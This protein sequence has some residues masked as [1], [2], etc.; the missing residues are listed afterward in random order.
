MPMRTLSTSTRGKLSKVV[1]G[2][3]ATRLVCVS[4]DRCPVAVCPEL[5][6]CADAVEFRA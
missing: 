2:G 1:A 4:F 6:G 3:R 5:G